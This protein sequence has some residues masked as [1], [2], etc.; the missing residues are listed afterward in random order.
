M[1]PMARWRMLLLVVA[2]LVRVPVTLAQTDDAPV[3][4]DAAREGERYV[5][6]P[7]AEALLSEMLGQGQDLPGGCTFTNGQIE[8]SFV[9]ATYTCGTEQV[10]LRFLHPEAAPPGS[11]RTKA[12]A[13]AVNGTPP[14]ELV[15]AVADRVRAREAEFAWTYVGGRDTHTSR[16]KV[17]AVAALAVLT[18]AALCLLAAK[19]RRTRRDPPAP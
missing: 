10:G 11:V 18:V 16:W 9:V 3:P 13:I 5:I 8:R 2:V 14:D 7:G 12:F 1:S 15:A 6:A 17:A 19:R 4:V